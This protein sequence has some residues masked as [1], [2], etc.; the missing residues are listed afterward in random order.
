MENVFSLVT[1]IGVGAAAMYVLDPAAGTRRRALARDKI[2]ETGRKMRRA[3]GQ[4]AR[5]LGNRSAGAVAEFRSRFSEKEVGDEVLE[6][7]VRSKLGFLVR[8]PSAITTRVSN[9]HVV[10]GGPVLSDEA[11]QLVD[12][13]RAV[14]G[15]I[16][17][18]SNL[19]VHDKAANVSGLQGDK[20]RPSGEVWDIMQRRWSPAT[21]FLVATAG[22]ASLGFIAFSFSDGSR[23]SQPATG[24][25]AKL[26][27]SAHKR[28][29]WFS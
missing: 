27:P 12:G 5:D 20:S 6:G 26:H 23:H 19:A 8:H 21:R 16:S 24:W 4:T 17:V 29:G 15:V 28:A 2:T 7:R 13:I 25:R 10:L 9:G 22:A 18:E 14:R 1:G 3:A 11:E